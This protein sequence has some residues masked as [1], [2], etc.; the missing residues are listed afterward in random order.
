MSLVTIFTGKIYHPLFALV[1][2]LFSIE[3]PKTGLPNQYDCIFNTQLNVILSAGTN[4][5]RL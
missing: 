1:I 5:S 3:Y 2:E 4:K